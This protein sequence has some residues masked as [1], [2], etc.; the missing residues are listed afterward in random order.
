MYEIMGAGNCGARSLMMSKP[1]QCGSHHYIIGTELGYNL[2]LTAM[3]TPAGHVLIILLLLHG[4]TNFINYYALE[5][6]LMYLSVSRNNKI[7]DYNSNDCT[8][9]IMCLAA[10]LDYAVI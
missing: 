8:A 4:H 7:G 10:I 6:L 9:A 3:D 5:Q 1:I 2:P